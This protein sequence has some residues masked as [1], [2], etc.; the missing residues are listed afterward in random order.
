M[1]HNMEATPALTAKAPTP[2][3]ANPLLT[4]DFH[5]LRNNES[6]SAR[7]D[8]ALLQQQPRAIRPKLLKLQTDEDESG[9][10][11]ATSRQ[12]YSGGPQQRNEQTTGSNRSR[13]KSK[14]KVSAAKWDFVLSN[15]SG[16]LLV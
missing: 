15:A 2:S 1:Q 13:K 10:V 14:F 5:L 16:R 4:T 8:R 6:T 12:Q 7:F 9:F 3:T 11:K